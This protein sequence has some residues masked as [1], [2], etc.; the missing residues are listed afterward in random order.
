MHNDTESVLS[1]LLGEPIESLSIL[2]TQHWGGKGVEIYSSFLEVNIT[3]VWVLSKP[4]PLMAWAELE[5][6]TL[7]SPQ[8]H[9]G[10]RLPHHQQWWS[11]GPLQT[12]VSLFARS[13]RFS[14]KTRFPAGKSLSVLCFRHSLSQESYTGFFPFTPFSPSIVCIPHQEHIT[15]LSIALFHC[16]QWENDALWSVFRSNKGG[17]FSRILMHCLKKMRF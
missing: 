13:K 7:C 3:A 1:I 9:M 16:F 14:M 5:G 2:I 6:R 17:M 10:K 15:S 12:D 8:T 4:Q 11:H